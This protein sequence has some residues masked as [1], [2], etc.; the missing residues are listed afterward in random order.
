MTQRDLWGVGRSLLGQSL[1]ETPDKVEQGKKQPSFC[2]EVSGP[3]RAVAIL[4]TRTRAAQAETRLR[5]AG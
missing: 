2:H 1:V 4:A 3:L 5:A